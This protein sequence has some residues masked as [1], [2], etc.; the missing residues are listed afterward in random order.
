[1]TNSGDNVYVW[2][3]GDGNRH[4]SPIQYFSV[5]EGAVLR[6]H[7]RCVECDSEGKPVGPREPDDPAF[8]QELAR[9]GKVWVPGISDK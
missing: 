9:S 4:E 5:P 3:D 8:L 7:D 6:Y 1:M 2:W